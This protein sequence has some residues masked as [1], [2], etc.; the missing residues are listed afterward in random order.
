MQKSI[1]AIALLMILATGANAMPN[2]F[3]VSPN[4]NDAWSGTLPAPNAM[5]TDGPFATIAGA[6]KAARAAKPATI[7]IRKG[8]YTLAKTLTFTASDSQTTYAAYPGEKP[9]ISGGKRLTGWKKSDEELW[10]TNVA[11]SDQ[12]PD[13]SAGSQSTLPV[14]HHSSLITAADILP[15]FRDLY[16]NGQRRNRTRLPKDGFFH[17]A[18]SLG[19]EVRNAFRFTEGDV[20]TWQNLDDVEVVAFNAWDELRFHIASVNEKGRIITF[21]GSNNWP[22]GQWG[23]KNQR[24]YVENVPQEL[25]PGQWYLDRKSGVLSYRPLP[26]EDMRKAEVIAPV[27]NEL[28]R[29]QGDE[30]N[31]VERLTIKGISFRYAGWDLAK[32]SYISIQ[33]AVRIPGVIWVGNAKDCTIEGCDISRVGQYGID[34]ASG[35][36][37][38]VKGN[39]I[40]DMGAGGVK[41]GAGSGNTITRNHVYDLGHTYPSAVGVWVGNS[42]HNTISYNHIHDLYYTGISVGWSWGY[43]PTLTQNNIIEHNHIHDIGKGLLSDMGGIYTLGTATGSII[44]YNLIHNVDSYSYGGWGIYLD[45]GTSGM[46]VENNIVYRTTTGGFHQHYGKDNLIRNNIF[47]FS[48]D[49]QIQR[50]RQEAHVSFTFE[51]NIVFWDEGYML[52]GNWDDPTT[53]KMDYNIYWTSKEANWFEVYKGADFAKWQTPEREAHSILCDPLFL[54]PEHGDFRLGEGSP[55]EKLGFKPIVGAGDK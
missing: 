49:G 36:G 2:S 15:Y 37:M 4:G 43:N 53:Y 1:I 10:T 51:H 20:K 41:L 47:A 5:H 3:Y 13:I 35:N 48:K 12:R 29:I 18:E 23:Q 32:E 6:Q 44:R 42:G 21:T 9:I 16:V 33:A 54:D 19:N 34:I 30:K 46:L 8:T 26:G 55:V 40:H 28:V 25:D 50:T 39:T 45:E 7:F 22:W 17:I 27:L 38:L 31:P 24:Y 52:R 14:T 11:L